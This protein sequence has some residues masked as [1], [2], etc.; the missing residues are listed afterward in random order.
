MNNIPFDKR[1]LNQQIRIMIFLLIKIQEIEM[2]F[3]TSKI[4]QIENPNSEIK[5]I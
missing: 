4:K 3:S 1:H 5:Q 2:D